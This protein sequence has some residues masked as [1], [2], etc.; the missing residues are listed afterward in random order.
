MKHYSTKC[1]ALATA[2]ILYASKSVI[3]S[4]SMTTDASIP[5]MNASHTVNGINYVAWQYAQ[6]PANNFL[7]D[8]TSAEITVKGALFAAFGYQINQWTYSDYSDGMF[9]WSESNVA[10]VTYTI[11]GDILESAKKGG[12]YIRTNTSEGLTMTI[13]N[14]CGS[15]TDSQTP[16]D[17]E[18]TPTEPEITP[19]DPEVTPTEPETT[20]T[21]PEVTPTE[22]EVTP[23][24]PQPD[25]NPEQPTNDEK[26][27][28]VLNSFEMTLSEWNNIKIPA[29]AFS[30]KATDVKLVVSGASS[31]KYM[32]GS[33]VIAEYPW[34]D[35]TKFGAIL[36]LSADQIKEGLKGNLYTWVGG[37]TP[38]TLTVLCYGMGGTP[39]KLRDPETLD[40]TNFGDR[41]Y[42]ISH[43]YQLTDVPTL[44]LTI[45]DAEGK[46]INT[47][48]YKDRATNT[49]D[50]HNVTIQ[51]VDKKGILEEF[52]EDAEIKVRGNSTSECIKRP[53]RIKFPKKNKH[54]MLGNG[55]SKR[56]WVLLA[57][58]LDPAMIRN[59]V[60]YH[61]GKE[62]GMEFCPGYQFADV[63]INDEYRGTY[64]ITD[65]VEVGKG[66]IDIDEDNGWYIEVSRYDM[67][68]EPCLTVGNLPLS[69]KNPEPSKDS[70]I[71]VLKSRVKDWFTN[72]NNAFFNSDFATFTSANAGWRAYL[73]EES[74]VNFYI[75]VNI[76][77]DYDGFMTI[78]MFRE[79]DGKMHFGPLWDKDLSAGNYE[80]GTKLI[81]EYNNGAFVNYI[82]ALLKD[83]GFVNKIQERLATLVANGLEQNLQ[84][85]VS[86]VDSK[87]AK[88]EPLNSTKWEG[89]TSWKQSFTSHAAAI[90]QLK[91]Y[92]KKHVSVVV[93]KI[94]QK[95]SSLGIKAKSVATSASIVSQNVAI[96]G[97]KGC[98]TISSNSGKA[99][100]IFS[101]TGVEIARVANGG[102]VALPS[103]TYIVEGRKVIVE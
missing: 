9:N 15:N 71:A 45:P 28:G 67:I 18:V 65:Q 23:T 50:Y 62:L 11:S 72:L 75:A 25:T 54:D 52:T 76:A 91:D 8:A 1:I 51:L 49:A 96:K 30:D 43:R 55:Y 31:V 85:Y 84:S 42:A 102:T 13:N 61:I 41:S 44:Y 68:E 21:E 87:I 70:E 73:D 10:G 86:L 26:V 101:L 17:P 82:N 12:L 78:K 99:I 94:N 47:V 40:L 32:V 38:I 29:E 89:Y 90:Q 37:G 69:I 39:E 74:L 16:T 63:V 103:G 100:S 5:T 34:S 88:T 77:G 92:Y 4:G 22:P 95:A 97:G 48:L 66:R 19:T 24:Q 2:L 59:A 80:D 6:I 60:S 81:E 57:N 35:N 36:K 20:P 3:A 79:K 14:I 58:Y 46:D 53:Y 64:Q 27:Y 83:P 7:A 33:A 98:I 93:E 56:N